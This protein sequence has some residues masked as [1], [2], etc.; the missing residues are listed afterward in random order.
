MQLVDGPFRH[1]SGTWNFLPLGEGGCKVSLALDFDYSGV[2]MAP[3]HA[4][5]FPETGRPHG[6]RILRRSGSNVWLSG[7]ASALFT[8]IRHC[9]SKCLSTS[10]ATATVDDAIR[11]SG[12]SAQL[13][14][15]FKP[16][17][18][19]IFGRTVSASDTLHDGD[20]IEL[21]RPLKIDP[22]EARRRRA[23]L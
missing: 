1:L 6:R 16:A 5:R 8:P 20:R 11:A 21:Y 3:D 22:K 14:K 2:L 13:P 19:G 17:A 15:G 4:H 23:Q 12:I 9:R 7:F 18:I 10:S